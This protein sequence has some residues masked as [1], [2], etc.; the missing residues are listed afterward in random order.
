MSVWL[1]AGVK[2]GRD[3]WLN[4]QVGKDIVVG[5]GKPVY[6]ASAGPT[7]L[8]SSEPAVR[9]ACLASNQVRVIS[10]GP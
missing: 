6:S 1:M 7:S 4:L 10:T 2:V 9:T 8:T 5:E 3:N